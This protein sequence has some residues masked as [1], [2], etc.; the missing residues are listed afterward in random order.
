[1]DERLKT[2][3]GQWLAKGDNDLKTAE[4]GLTAAEPVTDTICFHCQQAVEKYLK[5]YLVSNGDEPIITHN[6]SILVTKCAAYDTDFNELAKFDFLTGY[7]V[8]LRYPDDF[9]MPE[10]DETQEALAAAREAR[11]FVVARMK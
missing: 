7:A 10:I 8:T 5:M 4:F 9:Y 1:V 3:V 11:S 6:I 2:I